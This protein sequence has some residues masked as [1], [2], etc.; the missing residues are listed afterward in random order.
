MPH[1]LSKVVSTVSTVKVSKIHT[2]ASKERAWRRMQRCLSKLGIH[3]KLNPAGPGTRMH[4]DPATAAIYMSYHQF[5]LDWK[6]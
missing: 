3:V 2:V 4:A 5:T 6:Y 1:R